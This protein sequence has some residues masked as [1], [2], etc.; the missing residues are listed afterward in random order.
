MRD[1]FLALL[2]GYPRLVH[3]PSTM[4]TT[5]VALLK[6]QYVA[7]T[8]LARHLGRATNTLRHWARTGKL[9]AVRIATR[10]Y[11][12]ERERRSDRARWYVARTEVERFLRLYRSGA[13]S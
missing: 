4:R 13:L 10:H 5:D 7:L 12:D 2:F 11:T 1:L 8:A 6:H 3:S 9:N